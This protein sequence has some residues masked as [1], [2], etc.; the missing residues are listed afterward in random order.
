MSFSRENVCVGLRL[1]TLNIRA[2]Y[3]AVLWCNWTW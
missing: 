2:D 1:I 3:E